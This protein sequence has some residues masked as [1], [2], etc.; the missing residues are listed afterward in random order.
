MPG[1]RVMLHPLDW[2]PALRRCIAGFKVVKRNAYTGDGRTDTLWDVKFESSQKAGIALGE[3]HG[4]FEKDRQQGREVQIAKIVNNIH[5]GPHPLAE[6]R[7]L[8]PADNST[9]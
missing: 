2:P 3:H 1:E 7:K 5:M 4:T 9:T 8:L 6:A